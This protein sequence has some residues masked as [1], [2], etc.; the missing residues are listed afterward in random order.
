MKSYYIIYILVL[1]NYNFKCY[2]QHKTVYR[3]PT[4]SLVY[5]TPEFKLSFKDYKAK[6]P[7]Y[8]DELARTAM[9]ID[10]IGMVSHNC[11]AFKTKA[12]FIP[13]KSFMLC[14][15]DTYTLKHEQLHFD[16]AQIYNFKLVSYFRGLTFCGN[17]EYL[18]SQI[19]YQ[20]VTLDLGR[21]Q[22]IFDKD[23]NYG[24]DT[25]CHQHWE[26]Y[27]NEEIKRQLILN[28]GEY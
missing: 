19:D 3:F 5:W 23:T 28:N 4:D 15:N 12:F 9:N 22:D 8:K 26:K 25:L 16:L 13:K 20:A 10:I 6:K 1:L 2:S 7:F 17:R 11:H 24:F 18:L 14:D 27:I 21:I